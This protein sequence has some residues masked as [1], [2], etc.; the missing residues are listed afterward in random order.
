MSSHH[1]VSRSAILTREKGQLR[2]MILEDCELTITARSLGV[3]LIDN[4]VNSRTLEA[5]MSHRTLSERLGSSE[6]TI[7]RAIAQLCAG[8]YLLR[9]ERPGRTNLY[10]FPYLTRRVTATRRHRPGQE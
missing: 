3:I 9:T 6:R 2:T 7:Q 5:W 1:K 8:G 10:E 4:Y